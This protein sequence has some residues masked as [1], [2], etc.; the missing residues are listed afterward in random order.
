TI[1]ILAVILSPVIVFLAANIDT[2]PVE[3][4]FT[5]KDIKPASMEKNNGFY[6]LLTLIEPPETDIESHEVLEKYRDMYAPEDHAHQ[7]SGT[8]GRP[9]FYQKWGRSYLANR[10]KARQ[11]T[12]YMKRLSHF[13]YMLTR[14]VVKD[15][16]KDI[17]RI[18]KRI[19]QYDYLLKR[20]EKVLNSPKME[21]F[22]KPTLNV[23]VFQQFIVLRTASFYTVVKIIDA[24]K[25]D[26]TPAV[27]GLLKQVTFAKRLIRGS[28]FLSINTMGKT[29]MRKSL[30]ALCGLMNQKECPKE[31]Y[32]L[33]SESMPP[34]KPEEYQLGNALIGSYLYAASEMD[35]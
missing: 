29:I 15:L 8:W 6:R 10:G 31:I 20:Y 9:G 33:I 17:P 18:E 22:M 2:G 5:I 4:E 35:Y 34:L 27:K 23:A 28:R 13:S 26:W 12:I 11:T 16:I 3:D 32:A 19:P 7:D 21:V 25:G 14:D 30:R 24:L 1:I